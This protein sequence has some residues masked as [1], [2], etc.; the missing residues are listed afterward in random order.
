MLS[1]PKVWVI[2]VASLFSKITRY[3]FMFWLPLYLVQHLRYG[4]RD[5]GFFSSA[6]E[7]AGPAGSL[8]AGYVS[9]RLMRARRLPVAV[10]M[11]W[12]LAFACGLH[13]ALARS[14]SLGLVLSIA[15][16]GLMNHGPDALLQGAAAQDL[17]AAWGVGAVAGFVSGFAAIGQVLAPFMVAIVASRSGW[18]GLFYVLM[19]LALTGGALL[20]FF[21]RDEYGGVK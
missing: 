4:V 3:S 19:A 16:L 12:G 8:L 17:G 2:A 1:D 14:G 18:E 11:F 7:L 15:L 21:S 13:P 6:F 5:A 20:A 9:D 10:F